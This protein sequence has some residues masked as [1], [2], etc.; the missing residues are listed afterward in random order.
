MG[1]A[2]LAWWAG[3]FVCVLGAIESLWMR[4]VEGRMDVPDL[5]DE[6]APFSESYLDPLAI[7]AAI[8][9]VGSPVE[10]PTDDWKTHV[11]RASATS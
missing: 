3:G 7:D 8:A 5:S 9:A 4:E 6:E 1:Y 11:E 10:D 2:G